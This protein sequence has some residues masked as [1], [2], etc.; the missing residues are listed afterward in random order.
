VH[1]RER[2]IAENEARFRALN[3]GIEHARS[4]LPDATFE[5][6][7]ECGDDGCTE[8]IH[9][10]RDEYEHVRER[11]NRFAL[12]P[13]HELEEVERVV[14]RHEQYFV[15]EKDPGEPSELVDRRDPRR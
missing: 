9:L 3:E 12:R 5:F 15:I 4:E 6:V 2:Q 11:G 14:E 10:T 7:C 13:G 8:R 1:E